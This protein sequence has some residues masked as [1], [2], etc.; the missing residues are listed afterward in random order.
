VQRGARMK[1]TSS[2]VGVCLVGALAIACGGQ[3]A[4]C[5]PGVAQNAVP[6]GE[7]LPGVTSAQ[8]G[9]D[10]KSIDLITDARCDRSERCDEI[11]PGLKYAT[12]VACD[13]QAGSST[14]NDL[15]ATRCP[16]GLDKDAVTRCTS[17]INTEM[18]STPLDMLIAIADC[19]TDVL[20]ED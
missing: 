17:A 11:G 4:Q 16:H 6:G 3:G 20:C 1:T 8:K 18:C 14:A 12:R 9:V 5:A 2:V 19:R 15:S 7:P 10:Q 13:Q